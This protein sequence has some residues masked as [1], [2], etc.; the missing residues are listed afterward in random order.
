MFYAERIL[1]ISKTDRILEVGPGG[2]AHPRADVFLD[3]AFPDAEER[4]GQRGGAPPL[5][6]TKPVV[7]Y[8]GGR[9]P[10][11]DD[12]FDYVICS[13]VLEHVE[14]VSQFLSELQRVAPRGYLE[15][16]TPYYDYLY[17]FPQHT[18]LLLH[19]DAEVRWLPK[20]DTTLDS[21]RPITRLFRESFEAGHLDL[22]HALGGL[23]FQGFEWQR[24]IA[25]RRV[26]TLAE[27]T[28]RDDEILIPPPVH[29]TLPRLLAWAVL[30]RLRLAGRGRRRKRR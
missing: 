24:P 13:H 8:D 30:R 26:S 28:Y 4:A 3:R 9:F 25:G 7:H 1:S 19:R 20:A 22:V 11:R 5:R 17:D 21:F 18:T 16:P 10:F 2:E 29:A 15:F 23:L 12:A 27:V 6:T 14:E